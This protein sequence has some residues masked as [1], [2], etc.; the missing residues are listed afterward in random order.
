MAEAATVSDRDGDRRDAAAHPQPSYFLHR[1]SPERKGSLM[2][3]GVLSV[4]SETEYDVPDP[5]RGRASPP[6]GAA[7]LPS[8]SRRRTI[9]SRRG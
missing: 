3:P 4:A 2:T 1:G 8:G 9:R 7:D 6:G 5:A